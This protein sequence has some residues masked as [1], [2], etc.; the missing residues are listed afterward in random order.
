M[1]RPQCEHWIWKQGWLLMLAVLIAVSAWRGAE[2]PRVAAH[3]RTNVTPMLVALDCRV[4]GAA[5]SKIILPVPRTAA[6]VRGVAVPGALRSYGATQVPSLR[7]YPRTWTV[8]LPLE[9][10]DEFL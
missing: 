2:T 8:L 6:G 9:L 3:G 5:L 10:E 4:R 7:V 1:A